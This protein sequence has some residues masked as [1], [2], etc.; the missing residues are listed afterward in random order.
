MEIDESRHAGIARG[1]FALSHSN[2]RSTVGSEREP[3]VRGRL[4]PS[5]TGSLHLGHARSFLIAWLAARRERGSIALRIEDIDSTRVRP[6]A[7]RAAI[8]D[9]AALGL[10][11]DEGPDCGGFAAPYVQSKRFEIYQEYLD[12]LI[13]YNYVYPC[14]CTRGDI[15][16]AAS[17]PHAGDEPVRY[18]GTCSSRSAADAVKL[19]VDSFAWRFR[20]RAGE[21]AWDDL[22]LGRRAIDLSRSGGDFV[23]ARVDRAHGRFTPAYQLAVTVDD[24]LMR[25]NRVVRGDD[26]VLST[27]RQIALYRAFQFTP[28]QFAHIPLGYDESGRRLAKRD[29]SITVRSLLDRSAD[30]R[31]LIGALARECGLTNEIVPS[32]PADWIDRFELSEIPRDKWIV[33]S[34]FLQE[35]VS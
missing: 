31:R 12:R 25:I 24:A 9:L 19:V 18:P 13:E 1:G 26:L 34:K 10:D 8:A 6:G 2:A 16:R 14:T 15:E 32:R 17:A 20:V 30:P 23:V 33:T 11:W 28:P 5:P 35:L 7:T 4:A 3:R 27:P 21:I 22:V 29:S